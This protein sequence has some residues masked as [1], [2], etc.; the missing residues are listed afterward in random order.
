[1]LKVGF[2]HL[3]SKQVTG[4]A[5]EH[6]ASLCWCVC[7]SISAEIHYQVPYLCF[8]AEQLPGSLQYMIN[9]CVC[10]EGVGFKC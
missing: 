5:K 4:E 1:M 9:V 3:I 2:P 7:P 10:K 8:H 6:G